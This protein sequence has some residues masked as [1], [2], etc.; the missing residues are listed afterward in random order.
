MVPGMV[1][2]NVV[3]PGVTLVVVPFVSI[4]MDLTRRC[5]ELGIA[6]KPIEGGESEVDGRSRVVFTTYE[7]LCQFNRY[8]Q[9]VSQSTL[10]NVVFD[11]CHCLTG[12]PK[13]LP[14]RGQGNGVI[15]FYQWPT[16]S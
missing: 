5:R 10:R 2:D 11:E 4:K 16:S 3:Q 13:S 14:S 1:D 12:D 15:L 8:Q 6:S 7:S 9:L